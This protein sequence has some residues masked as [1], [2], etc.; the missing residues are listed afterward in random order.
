MIDLGDRDSISGKYFHFAAMPAFLFPR[1][2]ADIGNTLQDSK[3]SRSVKVI[4][5][6][7]ITDVW[8]TSD[9]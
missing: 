5:T 7:F 9:Y 3:T 4:V 2:S 8:S 6:V 1:L